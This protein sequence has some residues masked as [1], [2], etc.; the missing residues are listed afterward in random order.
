MHKPGFGL[1]Y[2]D[3]KIKAIARLSIMA[4]LLTVLLL[5][6]LIFSDR[7]RSLVQ[8][9]PLSRHGSDYGIWSAVLAIMVPLCWAV[10]FG[11]IFTS[12]EQEVRFATWSKRWRKSPTKFDEIE[13]DTLDPDYRKVAWRYFLDRRKG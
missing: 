7:T 5:V 10:N 13:F 11:L 6:S 3:Q 8:H 4:A 1:T 9:L 12:P 2:Q